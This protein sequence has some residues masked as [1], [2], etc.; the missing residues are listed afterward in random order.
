MFQLLDLLL[1]LQIVASQSRQEKDVMAEAEAILDEMA[2]DYSL[3]N[4]RFLAY[5]FAKAFKRLY[6]HIYVNKSGLEKVCQAAVVKSRWCLPW[7]S[8]CTHMLQK[9]LDLV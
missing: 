8:F 2:H 1:F 7:C 4:I 9:V 3:N 5:I 6:K